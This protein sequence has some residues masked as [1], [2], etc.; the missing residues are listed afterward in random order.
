MCLFTMMVLLNII[1]IITVLFKQM[2]LLNISFP[3]PEYCFCDGSFPSGRQTINKRGRQNLTL[4][5]FIIVK[6]QINLIVSEKRC[7]A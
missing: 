2:L 3:L 5:L 7:D 4:K 1:M 6:V